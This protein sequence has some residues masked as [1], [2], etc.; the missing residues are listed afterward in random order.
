GPTYT[1]ECCTLWYRPPELLLGARIYGVELDLWSMAL[2][3]AEM[4]CG[5][6]L[7]AGD[8]EIGQ[9]FET[10]QLLGTPNEQMW[11]GVTKL[12]DWRSSFPQWDG[13]DFEALFGRAGDEAVD[14]LRKSLVY[15][16]TCRL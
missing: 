3:V 6:A 10:F 16:P 1:T 13:K 8:S 2:V 5:E 12:P 11:P 4:I 7:L 15:A 14:F 9:L